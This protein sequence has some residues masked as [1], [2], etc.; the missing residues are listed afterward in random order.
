MYRAVAPRPALRGLVRSIAAYDETSP[1][2]LVRR[3][4]PVGSCPLILGVHGTL[5][6]N[7]PDGSSAPT[8]FL[9]G[10]HSAPVY[11]TFTG[12][13]AGVQVDL[14]PTALLRLG[15][16]PAELA[17]RVPSIDRLDAPALTRLAE[18]LTDDPDGETRLARVQDTL[19]ALLEVS[20]R[21]PDP[22][23]AH[24]WRRLR[25]DRAGVEQLAREVGWSRRHLLTRFRDQI[26]VPPTL[27]ARVLRFRRAAD[28]L[29]PGTGPHRRPAATRIADVA[30][31]TG[32]A[33]HSHLVREFRSLAGCPPGVYL[34]EHGFPDVQDPDGPRS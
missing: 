31:A 33:D 19:C 20:P 29:V 15:L 9:A 17:D 14:D 1:G 5:R 34:A 27:A 18:Q 12:R 8:A 11:T 32:F 30:A 23:V 22:E 21:R 4:A 7:G 25:T 13:Q 10:L 28:L 2:P 16:G 6:L 26:G 3:Q 24:V